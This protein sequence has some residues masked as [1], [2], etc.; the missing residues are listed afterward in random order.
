M[1]NYIVVSIIVIF[2]I[3]A[4][5]TRY[6]KPKDLLL[7]EQMRN[8]LIEAGVSKNIP[9]NLLDE[10]VRNTKN[11]AD[12]RILF[13]LQEKEIPLEKFKE[14]HRYYTMYP[15]EYKEIFAMIKDSLDK[16][17]T[18]L[19]IEDSL[20]TLKTEK[21]KTSI[22]KQ[23]ELTPEELKKIDQQKKDSIMKPIKKKLDSLRKK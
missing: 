15:E 8:I 5:T 9:N 17:L 11:K 19:K 2:F 10:S 7:K 20:A 6:E 4:C 3:N 21:K 12:K 13:I 18:Q 23:K 22:E 14:S 1:K 16:Q